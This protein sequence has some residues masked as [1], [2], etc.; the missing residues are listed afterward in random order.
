MRETYCTIA[1]LETYS[2]RRRYINL[3]PCRLD[4]AIGGLLDEPIDLGLGMFI[5]ETMKFLDPQLYDN[6]PLYDY[7]QII[8]QSR[9]SLGIIYEFDSA[10]YMEEK[11]KREKLLDQR[12]KAIR[13][14]LMI[15]N[16]ALW[17]AKPSDL[18]FNLIIH[19]KK[20]IK[21][22][23]PKSPFDHTWIAQSISEVQHIIPHDRYAES[24]LSGDDLALARNLNTGLNKM[25]DN[26][27]I[28]TAVEVLWK[29]LTARLDDVRLLLLWVVLEALFGPEDGREITFRISQRIG[30]FLGIDRAAARAIFSKVKKSYGERSKVAHGAKQTKVASEALLLHI[31]ELEEWIRQALLRILNEP[32][33][34]KRFSKG[35]ERE[36]YLDDLPFKDL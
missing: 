12:N 16:L 28:L 30:F 25:W 24:T 29:A 13:R 3:N 23:E 32:D 34:G 33:V 20:A 9:H 26:K 11:I 22:H 14:L 5:G 15:A 18:G 4:S 8:N 2:L 19:S 27:T 35:K 21:E 31:L 1:P 17:L 10:E 7:Y 6:P 36:K